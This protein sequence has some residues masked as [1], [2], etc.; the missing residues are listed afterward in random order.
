MSPL[1][2]PF[3]EICVNDV[4][5]IGEQA[6]ELVDECRNGGVTTCAT[7]QVDGVDAWLE[8]CLN[9]IDDPFRPCAIGSRV[10]RFITTGTAF[11]CWISD[12]LKRST[13]DWTNEAYTFC[14]PA[15]P[16]LSMSL[17]YRLPSNKT[18]W[19]YACEHGLDA[20]N[21]TYVQGSLTYRFAECGS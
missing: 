8:D 15:V 18:H 19:D 2:V 14:N 12:S 4:T 11:D 9:D 20:E 10:V 1:P 5:G 16:L 6:L 7:S 17:E 21:C 13:Q 3:E